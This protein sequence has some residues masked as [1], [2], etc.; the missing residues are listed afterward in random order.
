MYVEF[1]EEETKEMSLSKMNFFN[2][3]IVHL[4]GYGKIVPRKNI[5]F[6]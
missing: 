1:Y 6:N 4:S 3:V 2:A 5:R